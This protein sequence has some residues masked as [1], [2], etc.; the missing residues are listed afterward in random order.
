MQPLGGQDHVPPPFVR[1]PLR[2]SNRNRIAVVTT[3]LRDVYSLS[4]CLSVCPRASKVTQKLWAD[5][6]KIFWIDSGC[7]LNNMSGTCKMYTVIG[8]TYLPIETNTSVFVSTVEIEVTARCHCW[9][10]S[11]NCRDND[12]NSGI[13]QTTHD[14]YGPALV[15]IM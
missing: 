6:D 3:S 10:A 1:T 7:E 5:F 13:S 15:C 11:W 9:C 14:Y 12:A 2:Q 4:V 8:C